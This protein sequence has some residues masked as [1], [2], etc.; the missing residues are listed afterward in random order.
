MTNSELMIQ[1]QYKT[2]NCNID[3]LK[4][5]LAVMVVFLHTKSEYKEFLQPLTT[6]AVPTFFMISGWLIFG[7]DVNGK[8]TLKAAW[9]IIKIFF[10]SLLLYIVVFYVKHSTFWIPD[11]K[12]TL[13]LVLFN[14]EGASG[15]L[16]YLSAYSYVLLIVSFL[17]HIKKLKWLPFIALFAFGTYF[18][19]DGFFMYLGMEKKL[20]LVYMFR[21]FFFTG[22]PF[23]TLG[24]VIRKKAIILVGK[25]NTINT[26][27]LI[28]FSILALLEIDYFHFNH[29][30]DVYFMTAPIAISLFLMSISSMCGERSVISDWG[31]Q[32]S[33]YIYII[34][35]LFIVV[36]KYLTGNSPAS[37]FMWMNPF[38]VL[39]VTMI[40][41][42]TFVYVKDKIVK[43][44][45]NN[46]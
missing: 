39:T 32:Y 4:F 36:L 1:N 24:A 17:A 18:V 22:I 8:N 28:V 16:W 46:K 13:L 2:R 30:A 41:S 7:R 9:R 6:C 21:N 33:L 31:R 11:F 44:I 19:C 10:W 45:S 43:I 37:I 38:I 42:V 20:T 27:I 3:V 23:F 40:F 34:H 35:P 15:H 29:I 26:I 12:D 5:I 14:N 25:Q